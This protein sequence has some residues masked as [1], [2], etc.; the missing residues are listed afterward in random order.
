MSFRTTFGILVAGLALVTVLYPQ[1][2]T[3][4]AS[5]AIFSHITNN[6][7]WTWYGEPKAVYYEG[8]HKRTY[9]G[10]LSNTGTVGVTSYDH[11][12]GDTLTHVIRLNY[13]LD[14]HAH[15]SI[16]MRP[17]GRLLVALAAHDGA[18]LSIYIATNPED[19]T[20]FGPE[21]QIHADPGAGFC[22]PNLL[23]LSAEGDRGRLYC[24]IRGLE[25][26]P[27]YLYSD[28]WGATW[29]HARVFFHSTDSTPKP[30]CKY[31]SNGKDE[32]HI[33][34]ER[35]NRQASYPTYYMKYKAGVFYQASGTP[36]AG[37]AHLPIWNS[38]ID[39][40]HNPGLAKSNGSVW[41]VAIDPFGRPVIVYDQFPDGNNHYYM[42]MRWTGTSWFK[43]T[44]L[45][46]G[47]N[48]GGQDGFA[49]GITLDHENPSIVYLA[50][51]IGAVPELDK[52]VTHDSGSTWD[53][54]AIT[55]G[56][57]KKNCRPC[58]PRGHKTGGNIELVWL[59]GDYT[60]YDGGAWNMA[61]NAYPFRQAVG[62]KN[63]IRSGALTDKDGVQVRASGI[64]FT[65]VNPRAS[66]LRLFSVDGRLVAD[67]SQDIRIRA[68]G[69]ACIPFGAFHHATGTCIV[70]FNDGMRVSTETLVLNR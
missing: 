15:P 6:G 26:L 46:A 47:A 69:A 45:N 48:M 42:Y 65:L 54:S 16:I 23:W 50:R 64:F 27:S 20:S 53:T 57:A 19:I 40:L 10:W 70:I 35:G 58:V 3:L 25:T 28:D 43:K 22:Y 1:A 21:I 2:Q 7:V 31:A 37:T 59:Y 44:L 24:F 34:I 61:V 63:P 29:T 33:T 36:I 11:D 60:G 49:S 8:T 62:T 17:D 12:T 18:I 38:L 14:D 56:S 55:R 52:W 66:S 4:P 39:T 51:Q 67:F 41:D 30:Y 68:P 13:D 9:V 32:V 5:G